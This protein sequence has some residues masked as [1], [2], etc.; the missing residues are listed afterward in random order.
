MATNSVDLSHFVVLIT[1]E[2]D[3]D[4]DESVLQPAVGDGASRRSVWVRH[5]NPPH[6]LRGTNIGID[7]FFINL[8]TVCL[9]EAAKLP[10]NNHIG[11]N[12]VRRKYKRR[13]VMQR[14]IT[15]QVTWAQP[16]L[17]QIIT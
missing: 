13:A 8:I 15:C 17:H 1:N 3:K 10:M 7:F 6:N 11:K 4:S 12:D 9:F 5:H 14:Q 2:G 16:T